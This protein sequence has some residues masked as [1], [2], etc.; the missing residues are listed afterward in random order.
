MV[1][2]PFSGIM[3][4]SPWLLRLG[5]K[6]IL[7]CYVRRMIRAQCTTKKLQL[8]RPGL[9]RCPRAGVGILCG[10]CNRIPQERWDSRAQGPV[11]Q[12]GMEEAGGGL[13]SREAILPRK[14]RRKGGQ[15]GS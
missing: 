1:T 15:H 9:E 4:F 8:T 13:G 2:G 14:L 3:A 6:D 12:L 7:N 11:G 5:T 10:C